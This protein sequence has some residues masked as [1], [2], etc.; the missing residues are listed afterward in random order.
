MV[1]AI[2][3]PA[4]PWFDLYDI[5]TPDHGKHNSW[6]GCTYDRRRLGK[7]SRPWSSGDVPE[8]GDNFL[9]MMAQDIGMA[10]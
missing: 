10:L 1:N 3:R 7:I 2:S 9:T 8:D 4:P 5:G 6:F